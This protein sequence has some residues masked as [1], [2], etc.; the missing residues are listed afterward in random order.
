VQLLQHRTWQ[1]GREIAIEKCEDTRNR[2]HSSQDEENEG[3]AARQKGWSMAEQCVNFRTI[4]TRKL[5][6]VMR[7][8]TTVAETIGRPCNA[9][10]KV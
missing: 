3:V 9:L 5:E 2:S 6:W 8:L 7:S 4:S 10:Y 1:Q